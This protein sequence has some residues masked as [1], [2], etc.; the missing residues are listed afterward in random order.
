[1]VWEGDERRQKPRPSGCDDHDLLT[2]IDVNLSN[3]MKRFDQHEEL[4][5]KRFDGLFKRTSGLQKFMWL[6]MG[7]FI[8]LELV[9][10]I[11]KDFVK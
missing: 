5:D 7:A 9:V 10:G 6:L 8:L 1:M 2:R 3:F 11:G 4:D